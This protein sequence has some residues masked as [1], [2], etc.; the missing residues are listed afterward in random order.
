MNDEINDEIDGS[1]DHERDEEGGRPPVDP[2]NK[3][4]TVISLLIFAVLYFGWGFIKDN[5]FVPYSLYDDSFSES[6]TEL[7]IRE[8]GIENLP[9]GVT[10]KYA[11]LHKY[12]DQDAF[13][14][15]FS[16]PAE[17]A[18]KEDFASLFIP[19]RYGD[20]LT[21]E[22]L[23][24]YPDSSD[25]PDFVYGDNYICIDDPSESCFIYRENEEYT[26]VFR[27]SGYSG[28]AKSAMNGCDKIYLGRR[29]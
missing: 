29:G 27:I 16:L 24:V 7:I 18:E 1:E 28:S 19:Y 14:A 6:D 25:V 21:D 4:Y 13:Y 12:H 15:A 3:L 26:A 9:R 5:L 20:A 22:R 17:L 2:K 23:T 8:L 10:L 11:R